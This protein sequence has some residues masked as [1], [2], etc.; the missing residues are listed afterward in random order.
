M[1]LQPK[2]KFVILLNLF[3]PWG[4]SLKDLKYIVINFSNG[5]HLNFRV[6]KP[7]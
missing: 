3:C 2:N 1:T 6:E 7:T 5:M 4:M